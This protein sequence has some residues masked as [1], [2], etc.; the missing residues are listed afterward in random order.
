M[1]QKDQFIS[2]CVN[3]EDKNH[4]NGH[5][6]FQILGGQ[7]WILRIFGNLLYIIYKGKKD[8]QNMQDQE[9]G[10]IQICLK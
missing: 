10:M 6:M 7:Q 5:K 1:L 9:H 2:Q 4:I 3:G 8:Y